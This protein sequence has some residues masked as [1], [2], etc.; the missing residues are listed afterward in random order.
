MRA[1]PGRAGGLF[2]WGPCEAEQ[3][4]P[5]LPF[6]SEALQ[7]SLGTQKGLLSSLPSGAGREAPEDP[8][9][10]AEAADHHPR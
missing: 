5:A 8:A 2:S 6:P 3:L 10:A 9:A 7:C 1:E 4:G